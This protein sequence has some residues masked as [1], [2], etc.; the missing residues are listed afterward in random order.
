MAFCT[1]P[2]IFRN[3]NFYSQ[4]DKHAISSVHFVKKPTMLTKDL[5]GDR[6]QNAGMEQKKKILQNPKNHYKRPPRMCMGFMW[7]LTFI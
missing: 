2:I 3:Q 5:N 1:S 7:V 6:G 4:A